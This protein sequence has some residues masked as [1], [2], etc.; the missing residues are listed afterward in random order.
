[1]RRFLFSIVGIVLAACLLDTG[2]ATAQDDRNVEIAPL[3][4][5][6]VGSAPQKVDLLL[7][8]ARILQLPTAARDVLVA[9]PDVADVVMRTQR[10]V[11][12]L[13]RQVGDTNVFFFDAEGNEILRL[14]AR[15]E[16][17]LSALRATLNELMPK[18]DVQVTS[19]NNNVF[20]SGRVG[21]A[22]AAE[23]ARRIA[24]RFVAEDANVVNMLEVS[25][26]QQVV[27]RVRV[28]EMQRTAIKE[29]GLSYAFS[30]VAGNFPSIGFN[31]FEGLGANA[32]GSAFAQFLTSNTSFA[33]LIDALENN[34]LV[35]TLAEP[36]LTAVSGEAANFLAGGEFPIPVSQDENT[37]TV[38]FRPFGIGLDFTPVVVSSG[39]ISLRVQTEVSALSSAG[40]VT[41]GGITVPALTV[42][43]AATTVEL[44]SGGSLVIA[45]LLQ[46]DITTSVDGIPGLKD[47]PVLG[48]LFRSARFRRE[49]TELVIAVTAYLVNPI[50]PQQVT[51][52][53][54]GFAP[55]SDIDR[56]LF[57]RLA[58]TYAKSE[59]VPSADE[60]KAP[61][62][63]IME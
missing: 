38:E 30:R 18:D 14:E 10:L 46:D 2:S 40:A 15:I 7:G 44:P 23:D 45:G 31:L 56:Y 37:I 1:M 47:L 35:K 8:K 50:E 59:R 60:L 51:L 24:R 39:H 62:G 29:L 19:V 42:R 43:R 5:L 41:I 26:D 57:G 27:L 36:N 32:A 33:V 6:D 9:N 11:Y 58:A 21:S 20:L 55:A 3:N 52:P 13:G 49:E 12:L 63:Y 16:L 48:A 4:F 28:A 25:A 17:D 22:A 34:G 53:T 61:T 54:D